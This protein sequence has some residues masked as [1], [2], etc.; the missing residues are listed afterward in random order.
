MDEGKSGQTQP[1]VRIGGKQYLVK[2]NFCKM[3][4]FLGFLLR[5]NFARF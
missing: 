2:F 3:V 5:L 4:G 1:A